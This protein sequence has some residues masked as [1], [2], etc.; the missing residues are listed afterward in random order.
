MSFLVMTLYL[1]VS[2]KYAIN[3]DWDWSALV[4]S[5]LLGLLI[6]VSTPSSFRLRVLLSLFYLPIIGITLFLYTFAFV[7]SVFQSCL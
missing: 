2:R 5:C 6:V 4:I 3:F 7:C 1:I